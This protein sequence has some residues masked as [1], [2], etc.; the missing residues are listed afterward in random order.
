LIKEKGP[1]IKD[2]LRRELSETTLPRW[3]GF[4]ENLLENNVNTGFFVGG[5]MTIADLTAWHLCG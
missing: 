3:L 5:T 2:E 1:K 4:L